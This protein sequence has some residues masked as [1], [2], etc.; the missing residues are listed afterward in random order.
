MTI[1][2]TWD[3]WEKNSCVFLW[4]VTSNSN[5]LRDK[6]NPMDCTFD[7]TTCGYSVSNTSTSFAFSYV[8]SIASLGENVVIIFAA[9]R[10]YRTEW[11]WYCC[12]PV[13][14][15]GGGWSGRT[16]LLP[17]LKCPLFIADS[18]CA[19]RWHHFN[20]S[21]I[22]SRVCLTQL[23]VGLYSLLSVVALSLLYLKWQKLAFIK[24]KLPPSLLY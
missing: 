4:T 3:W 16:I 2:Y 1:A 15:G 18:S 8:F 22:L 7:E 14:K 23:V 17:A 19:K 6:N 5:V 10:V 24:T 21:F 12:R 9:V 11:E 20:A 13:A